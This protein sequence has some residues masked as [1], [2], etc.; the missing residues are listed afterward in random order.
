MR[1]RLAIL[2]ATLD[3]IRERGFAA[4]SMSSVANAAHV[5][6]QTVYS[7]FGSREQ[8]VSQAVAMV[9][10][11]VWGGVQDRLDETRTALEY[12]VEMIVAGRELVRREPVLRALLRAEGGNPIFDDD[13]MSRARPV[14]A[15][16]L[17]P[18]RARAPRL[19]DSD[20]FDG[21]VEMVARLGL[22]IV[23]FDSDMVQADDDLRR[24]LRHCL[25]PFL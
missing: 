4:V 23:L 15:D 21:L 12:V 7:N 1:S 20:S 19:A 22:S 8:L 6:R 9:A 5:S 16:M 24:F 2:H 25:T 17:S 10:L 14:V 13:M 18:M 3:L 11:E